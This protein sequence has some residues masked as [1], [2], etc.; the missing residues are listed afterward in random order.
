MPRYD[1]QGRARD[2]RHR[3][4]RDV[5][6]DARRA[7]RRPHGGLY[8]SMGAPRRRTNVA[9]AVQGHGRALRRLRL[10]PRR[11]PG[12][13]RADR[14][15]H[16][17]RRR[18]RAPTAR[19]ALPGLFVAGE[20][21]GGVHGANRLG[22]NGVANSTV[23]GAVAGDAMAAW[24]QGERR[25]ASPTAPRSRPRSQRCERPFRERPRGEPR[26]A[27]RAALRRDVGE[28]RHPARRAR[29]C[30]AAQAE[31]R[32]SRRR[33]T[34]TALADAE[35]RLQPD[36]ARLAEPEEPGRREPRDR[37]AAIARR[38]SRGAHFRADFPKP[39]RSS[40][41]RSPASQDGSV[42]MKPVA[43]TRVRPGQTLLANVA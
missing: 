30:D 34:R 4:A 35:P 8:I 21:S 41:R 9:Q 33:W 19:T 15:L 12:G 10:R 27:A 25:C 36:L 17:G 22:G 16:D 29:A 26:A 31:L 5:R 43:F 20:D 39:G 28:G 23:F 38:D 13:S 7:T 24:V 37:A 2:A 11:R 40:S 1:P 42:S 14:A 32:R 6:G 3:L 18:V